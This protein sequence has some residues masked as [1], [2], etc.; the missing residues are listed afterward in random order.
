MTPIAQAVQ[1]MKQRSIDNAVAHMQ[2]KIDRTMARLEELNWDSNEVAPYPHG[3]NNRAEYLKRQNWY[4]FVQNITE[5]RE[6]AS[7]SNKRNAPHFV[8]PSARGIE[9]MLKEVAEDAGIAF[10]LY[11]K[12]LNDKVGEV[13][14]AE[15]TTCWSLWMNS[16]LAVTKADGT[17]QNW[18]TKCI[19]N[20]SKYNKAFNQFPTRLTK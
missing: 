18:N 11:V 19:T 2:I 12:K 16:N 15:V 4:H 1:P 3:I 8:Q 17:K 13:I 14:N 9:R 5:A 7:N 6:G 10:E 20:Y